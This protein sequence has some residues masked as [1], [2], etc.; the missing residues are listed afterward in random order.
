ME[1]WIGAS[2]WRLGRTAEDRL[3]YT[4]SMEAATSGNGYKQ[5]RES[6]ALSI[7]NCTNFNLDQK[8]YTFVN[9]VINAKMNQL[10]LEKFC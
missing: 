1:D 3:M 2:V 5:K 10:R 8:F 7:V 6:L 4:R 9:F